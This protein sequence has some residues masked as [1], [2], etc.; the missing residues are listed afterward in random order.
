M[1]DTLPFRSQAGEAARTNVDMPGTPRPFAE[2]GQ[3]APGGAQPATEAMTPTPRAVEGTPF[4][5]TRG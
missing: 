3:V 2:A 5:V 4:R 1:A